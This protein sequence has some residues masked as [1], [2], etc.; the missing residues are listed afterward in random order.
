MKAGHLAR[1]PGY[2]SSASRVISTTTGSLCV[3][4]PS[5]SLIESIGAYAD[6]FPVVTTRTSGNSRRTR[7]STAIGLAVLAWFLLAVIFDTVLFGVFIATGGLFNFGGGVINLPDWFFAAELVVPPD[8][9]GYFAF[10][11]FGVEQ[12]FGLRVQ[13]PGFVTPEAALL[14]LFLW[15]AVPLLLALWWF[16]TQYL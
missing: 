5:R 9:V 14:S 2:S 3:R 6:A 4:N 12:T 1:S 11:L 15:T 7:R 13:L 10:T 16:R 8:A